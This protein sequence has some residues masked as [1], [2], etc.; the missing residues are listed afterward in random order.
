MSIKTYKVVCSESQFSGEQFVDIAPDG[1]VIHSQIFYSRM[2]IYQQTN[3]YALTR[4]L[5]AIYL[6]DNNGE[7]SVEFPKV[8]APEDSPEYAEMLHLQK[9]WKPKIVQQYQEMKQAGKETTLLISDINQLMEFSEANYM[10]EYMDAYMLPP[11]PC[12]KLQQVAEKVHRNK[13]AQDCQVPQSPQEERR[14]QRQ[15]ELARAKHYREAG[16]QKRAQQPLAA[17]QRFQ[18]RYFGD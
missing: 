18:E 13:S 10:D 5:D 17:W 3:T 14:V 11:V 15:Q 4:T 6:K 9:I 7:I 8:Q 16:K 12:E 2:Q 1:D